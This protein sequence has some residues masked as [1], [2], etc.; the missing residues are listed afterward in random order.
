MLFSAFSFLENYRNNTVDNSTRKVSRVMFS[1]RFIASYDEMCMQTQ[2][3]TCIVIRLNHDGSA[4]FLLVQLSEKYMATVYNQTY[5]PRVEHIF[6]QL[7]WNKVEEISAERISS[8]MEID[9]W[10]R[11]K[12]TKRSVRISS[13]CPLGIDR[14]F[15][16]IE[17]YHSLM[18]SCIVHQT[19]QQTT[20]E[21]TKKFNVFE[22]SVYGNQSGNDLLCLWHFWSMLACIS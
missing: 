16:C 3:G 22:K 20:L 17:S 6:T 19:H 13:T 18:Y 10:C 15:V 7:R 2:H 9:I 11:L 8:K 12:K 14:Q 5:A 4:H 1:R 21:C